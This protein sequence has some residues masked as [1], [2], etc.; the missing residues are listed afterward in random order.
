M[1][2]HVTF[3]PKSGVADFADVWFC[4][5]MDEHMHLQVGSFAK[6]FVAA[7]EGALEWLGAVVVV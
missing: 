7:S 3:G 6:G 1:V 4:V 5:Q 2:L